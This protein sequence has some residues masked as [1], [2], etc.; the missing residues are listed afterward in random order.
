MYVDTSY[1][2]SLR[3]NFT[4]ESLNTNDGEFFIN[5]DG[6]GHFTL[7]KL[8]VLHLADLLILI[9]FLDK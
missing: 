9:D 5:D 6:F 4:H 1:K 8:S 2:L 3:G 7:F